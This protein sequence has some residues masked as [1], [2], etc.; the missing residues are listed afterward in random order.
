MSS[1]KIDQRFRQT[2]VG[3]GAPAKVA[4]PAK[5]PVAD[6]SFSNFSKFSRRHP[7]PDKKA[8]LPEDK[9]GV[10]EQWAVGYSRLCAMTRPPDFSE[11][12]WLR[13]IDDAGR[14]LQEWGHKAAA[15]G[16]GAEDLFGVHPV[17]PA[18]RQDVKGLILLLNGASV[19]ALSETTCSVRAARGSRQTYRRQLFGRHA[20]RVLI[21]DLPARPDSRVESARA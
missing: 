13:L 15:L 2:Y 18:A 12:G 11:V 8:G 19:E 5:A 6:T 9:V 3:R 10:P 7:A 20:E 17:A 16:W 14:F 1:A 21:W 4:N